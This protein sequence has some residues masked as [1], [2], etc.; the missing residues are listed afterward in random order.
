MDEGFARVKK[1][2]EEKG[3]I[4]ENS[5]SDADIREITIGAIKYSYLSQ[6]RERDV[7]FTWDKSLN[8]EGNSGPYIQYA[9]VRAKKIS[10]NFEEKSFNNN[11]KLSIYDKNP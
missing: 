9:F 10:E 11:L 1:I 7:V 4:G 5:L 2:L 6:D 8:F 3:R